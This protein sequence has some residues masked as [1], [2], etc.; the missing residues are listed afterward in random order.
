MG[1]YA[2]AHRKIVQDLADDNLLRPDIVFSHGA[3]LTQSELAAIK[4]S[5]AGIV[6]TPD[7]E[8]QMGVGHPVAF[9][10]ADNGCHS[11]LGIDITSSNSNDFM[12][13]M[14]L[15]LQAQRA[16]DNEEKFPKVVKR[17]IEEVLRMA[18]IGGAEVMRLQDLTGL[19]TPEKKRL[20]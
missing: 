17:K 1:H 13:Q 16:N 4:V 2:M 6:A 11:C 9:H 18:A 10:A 3:S 19:I 5:G 14:R 12:A 8:L 20:T 15:A 7:T